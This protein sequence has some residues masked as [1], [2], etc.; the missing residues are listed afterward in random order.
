VNLPSP[1]H[2]GWSPDPGRFLQDL[3]AKPTWLERLASDAEVREAVS[4][5]PTD[6]RR[7]LF[8]G[9]GSSRFAAE[10]AARRLRAVGVHAVSEYASAT[11]LPPPARDTLV[12][13][14][15]ATGSSKETIE[16]CG[17][18]LG[19]SPTVALTEDLD[20]PLARASDLVVPLGA[21]A[22]SGGVA[23]R[24][25]LHTGL[26]LRLLESRL[27]ATAFDLG[28]LCGRVATATADLLDRRGEWLDRTLETLDSP[29]GVHVI[30]PAERWS[31]VAQSALMFREG[32]R[33]PATASETGDWSHIDVYL[34]KTTDYRAILLTGSRYDRDAMAW[35]EARGSIVVT[36]GAALA[37]AHENIAFP[38][39]EDPAVAL[40]T[41]TLVSELMAASW[42]L[43]GGV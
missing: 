15:S 35:I 21:G 5:I 43:A 28:G 14:I 38:G 31:S 11:L 26:V 24:S 30:G 17:R 22:E 9:M 20:S 6:V 19:V 29:D 33:R 8:L 3:E 25:F 27:L 4:T 39:S 12:V 40:H 32:P 37:G 10:D 18:Y 36:V 13:A 2:D 16:A 7:V 41:E 42:W 1:P 23:C 34:T